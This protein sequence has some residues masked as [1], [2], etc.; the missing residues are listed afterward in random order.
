[1]PF[2]LLAP[3]VPVPPLPLAS[4]HAFGVYFPIDTELARVYELE[5][6]TQYLELGIVTQEVDYPDVD[7]QVRCVL[8][9]ATVTVQY[10]ILAKIFLIA[11]GS[12]TGDLPNTVV[13]MPLVFYSHNRFKGFYVGLKLPLSFSISGQS[14]SCI[15]KPHKCQMGTST[16]ACLYYG[17]G[18]PKRFRQ[19]TSL[20]R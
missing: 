6:D 19:S 3:I 7:V 11:R 12:Q 18:T 14:C 20:E 4:P 13:G 9:R 15:M 17:V 8:A 1:M 5:V 2:P 16:V 10:L